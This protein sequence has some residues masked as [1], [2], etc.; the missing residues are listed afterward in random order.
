MARSLLNTLCQSFVARLIIGFGLTALTLAII[1]YLVT[2]PNADSIA[3]F[4]DEVR[5][6]AQSMAS[7][8]LTEVL[9]VI[10]RLGS[11]IVL[12]IIGSL[13]VIAFFLLRWRRAVSV[14]LLA[15]AGQI[16]LHEG[17]KFLIARERPQ[18]SFGYIVDESHSFPSGHALASA[19]L[20]G[21]LVW[22]LT[23]RLGSKRL[24]VTMWVAAVT[25][26]FLIGFSRV[27]FN[28]HYASDVIAGFVAAFIWTAAVASG[29]VATDLIKSM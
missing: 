12:T 29:D 9:R 17:F 16:I 1:G 27:Y 26:V 8:S 15:M 10:T 25:L 6:A 20:Y 23:R 21:I 4:D 14:F 7:T 18:G 19:S 13:A 5:K 3:S 28:V 22:I 11:T 2:G 24:A